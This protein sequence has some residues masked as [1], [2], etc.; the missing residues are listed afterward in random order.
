VRQTT[1]FA[2]T[3][4]FW[5]IWLYL[6]MPL[7]SILLWLAG[8]QLFVDEM[9]MHEGYHALIEEFTH[10]SFVVLGMLITILLW[11]NW[12]LRHYGQ[13]NLRIR[14]P[15]PVSIGEMINFTGLPEKKLISIHTRRHLL[16]TFDEQD[17]LV[18]R[19][20]KPERI[21]KAP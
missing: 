3:A 10:Y 9:I 7:L 21:K 8:V 4:I 20:N 2:I 5:A 18:V 16:V 14:Q 15:P 19:A 1:E 12:N 6:V 11:V 13:R 17:R